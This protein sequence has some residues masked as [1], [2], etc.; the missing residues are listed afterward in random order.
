MLDVLAALIKL[1]E[2]GRHEARCLDA[3][4]QDQS[5]NGLDQA[6]HHR[7]LCLFQEPFCWTQMNSITFV[8]TGTHGMV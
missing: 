8:V 4:V 3:E 6:H 5:G 7:M 1:P 2:Q